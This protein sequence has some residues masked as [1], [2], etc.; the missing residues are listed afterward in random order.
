MP[1]TKSTSQSAAFVNEWAVHIPGGQSVADTVAED[2]GYE[3]L[4]QVTTDPL[5]TS[6]SVIRASV[7]SNTDVVAMS[8]EC[9]REARHVCCKGVIFNFYRLSYYWANQPMVII[10]GTT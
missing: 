6:H 2:L 8:F 9:G 7:F 10:V 5:S 3:N 1:A 4:G